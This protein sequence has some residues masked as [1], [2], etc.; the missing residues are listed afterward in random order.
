MHERFLDLAFPGVV[1]LLPFLELFL[2]FF[3][4]HLSVVFQCFQ[5]LSLKHLHG[6]G[7]VASPVVEC[8]LRTQGSIP[9][10]FACC[11]LTSTTLS[12]LLAFIGLVA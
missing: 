1:S 10:T 5:T 6:A 8:L 12:W 4:I 9:D 11:H 7:H 2:P 3:G